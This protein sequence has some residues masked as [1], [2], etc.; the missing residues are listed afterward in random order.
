MRNL[1]IFILAVLLTIWAGIALGGDRNYTSTE[2]HN[3]YYAPPESSTTRVFT[4]MNNE[5]F[6]K[7][8]AMSAAGDT[9]IFDYA[10]GWQGCFGGGWYGSRSAINGSLATR[11]D[12]FMIRVNLQTDTDFDEQAIGVGGSWHF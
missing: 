12:Q 1:Q 3:H 6:D 2:T 11:V 8:M 4:G 7:G 10:Q 5:E 9:C